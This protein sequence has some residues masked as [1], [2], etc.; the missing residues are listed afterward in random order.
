M[1][2][3]KIGFHAGPGGNRTGIG[4]Y[5]TQLANAGISPSIKSTD[6]YGP[7][8]E[9]AQQPIGSIVF[10]LTTAGQNDGYN[11]DVPDYNKAPQ[12]AAAEHWQ[13]TKAKLPPELNKDK[14]WVEVTNEVDKNKADWLG[15]FGIA[16]ASLAVPQGYKVALFGFS[17]GEPEKSNWMEPGMASFLSF[18]ENN[19]NKVAVSLHEYSYNSS[20]P[21]SDAYP[22]LIGRFRELY[23]VCDTLGIDYPTT[24]ITE[25]GWEYSNIQTDIDR[26][27]VD[28]EWAADL[29]AQ[30]EDILGVN[31]WYL[32]GGFNN[33]ADKAQRLIAPVTQEALAY[34]PAP[35]PPPPPNGSNIFV[36][37][38]FENGYYNHNGI[39]ELLIPNG[40]LWW[41]APEDY[42]NWIDQNP[43]SV[44]RR[45]EVRPVH[46]NQLPVNEQSLYVYDGEYTLKLFKNSGAWYA[47]LSQ[48]VNLGPGAYRATFPI[49]AD[50][51]KAY[52]SSGDKIWAD[53]PQGRDGMVRIITD[54]HSTGWISL[55]P[56]VKNIIAVE[57]QGP[58]AAVAL[59]MLLPFA[60]ENSGLFMD[61]VKLV[62]TTIPDPTPCPGL[63]REDYRRLVHVLPANT[64]TA[65]A[66]AVFKEAFKTKSTVTG[67]YD[68]AGIG[69][70]TN[71]TAVLWGIPAADKPTYAAW[72]E[73]EYPGTVY[74]FRE[75]SE[76]GV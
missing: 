43:W 51:V 67:S 7:C 40:W 63:P 62:E 57:F 53:D 21:L 14:V 27:L 72:F 73:A 66:E 5:I 12:D 1:S 58:T 6:D 76:L 46:K 11:Y 34:N 48:T 33:I 64:S 9:A 28:L 36:N 16:I 70:L 38:S 50:L 39:N 44:F 24:L 59:D 32:G 8:F 10:R 23:S 22:H 15:R 35:P 49:F 65:R 13:R 4:E 69:D 42:P 18:C 68:D 45:P 56:G 61:D 55:V 25:F 29:Y 60:L 71:K 47:T 52:S 26:A 41:N 30:Y 20:L 3:Y 74:I 54:Q 2:Y 31:L 37:G 17:A 19:K 75:F